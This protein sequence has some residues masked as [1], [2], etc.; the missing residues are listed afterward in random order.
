M[1]VPFFRQTVL[2]RVKSNDMDY[3][4]LP[5]PNLPRL[6]L[7]DDWIEKERKTIDLNAP[8]LVYIFQHQ[9]PISF[10][11]ST[12]SEPKIYVFVEKCL[13]LLRSKPSDATDLIQELRQ[14]FQAIHVSFPPER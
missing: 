9:F 5:E 7:K 2:M 14:V 4:F 1:R 13:R 11:F 8:H 12:V 6:R 3:R 10:A